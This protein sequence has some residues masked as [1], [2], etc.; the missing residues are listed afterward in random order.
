M[1]H[2]DSEAWLQL[3]E[4]RRRRQKLEATLRS[5]DAALL[6][7]ERRLEVLGAELAAEGRD[8]RKLEGLSLTALFHRVLGDREQQLQRERQELLGA[9]LRYDA[10]LTAAA[11]LRD[12]QRRCRDGLAGLGDLEQRRATLLQQREQ[13]L[14]QAG[15]AAAA[16]L[17]Q[18]LDQLA[19]ARADVRELDEAI[20]A[21]EE[22][23]FALT[24]AASELGSARGWGQVDLF[25]GGLI[26][27]AIK[28]SHIDAARRAAERAQGRLQRFAR[29]LQDVGGRAG[30][31]GARIAGFERFAD[32]FFDGLIFD[33]IVQSK[34][35]RAQEEVRATTAQVRQLVQGLQRRRRQGDAARQQLETER[36]QLLTQG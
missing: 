35:A 12:E 30:F 19:G 31:A 1:H 21:G 2:P 17:L 11:P 27:T 20:A 4:D 18:L 6:R 8:V 24:E 33:W 15:G 28:H 32:Y 36:E 9:K 5:V 14:R 7:H 16:P 3:A 23:L 10:E 26:T 34:I 29:E 25:G 13:Q 22:A